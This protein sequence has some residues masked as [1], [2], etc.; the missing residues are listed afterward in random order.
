MVVYLIEK[1]SYYCDKKRHLVCIPYSI[2]NLHEMAK[3][4]NIKKCWFHKTHYDIPKRRIKE[5]FN[6]CNIVDSKTILKIIK[7]G[8]L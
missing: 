4:L 3:I 8:A 1:L 7:G 5:V 6:K 2:E